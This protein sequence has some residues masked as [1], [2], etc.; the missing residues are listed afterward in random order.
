[1]FLLLP[2]DFAKQAGLEARIAFYGMQPLKVCILSAQATILSPFSM[3]ISY[4]LF[5]WHW[6]AA[7]NKT[8][9][10]NQTTDPFVNLCQKLMQNLL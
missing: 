7:E 9:Q 4:R 10:N 5:F 1:M 2:R 3:F 8:S 6:R